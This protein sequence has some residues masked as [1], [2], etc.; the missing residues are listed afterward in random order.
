MGASFGIWIEIATS[1]LV[2]EGVLGLRVAVS[3][4]APLIVEKVPERPAA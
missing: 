3:V 1:G 4:V 2:L